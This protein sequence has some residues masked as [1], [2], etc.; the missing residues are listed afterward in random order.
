MIPQ[1]GTD[2]QAP[3]P[4]PQQA[5]SHPDGL[6]AW[7]GGLEVE[8]LLRAYR[9]GIFPWY[10]GADPILWWCPATRCVLRTERVHVSRRLARTLRQGRHSLT[11][12][13]AFTRVIRACGGERDSTWITPAMERAYNALHRQGVAHS[14]EVWQDGDLVGGL[15]GL[16]LGRMFFGESMYS[17]ARDASKIALV[18]LCRLLERL[19][20]PLL[21]CQLPNP[22]L[23]RMGAEMIP[24]PV[25]LRSLRDLT[26]QRTPPVRW[27]AQLQRLL[28]EAGWPPAPG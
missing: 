20:F 7:G 24:R 25:F 11:M 26:H 3:F 16:A 21:D 9:L 15:Y 28:G 12:D 8:R 18:A 10:S 22:H 5:L 27:N 17:Q 1:L 23:E 6:L 13:Q 2:P 19:E 4:P 14:I